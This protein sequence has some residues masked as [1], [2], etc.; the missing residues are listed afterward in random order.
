MIDLDARRPLAI[1]PLKTF[2]T[3]ETMTNAKMVRQ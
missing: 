1:A 2:T 3:L